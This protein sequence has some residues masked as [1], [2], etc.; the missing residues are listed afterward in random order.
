MSENKPIVATLVMKA[1]GMARQRIQLSGKRNLDFLYRRGAGHVREY[2]DIE[3]FHQEESAL[4]EIVRLP[5]N[6]RTV[7]GAIDGQAKVK[8]ALAALI[9][10]NTGHRPTKHA[11]L[12]ELRTLL[13]AEIARLEASGVGREPEK[14]DLE[15][16]P[17]PSAREVA[18]ERRRAYLRR[19]GE[20]HTRNVVN[21]YGLQIPK[22]NNYQGM[23][24][25]VIEREFPAEGDRVT[26]EALRD[27]HG[28]T[29]AT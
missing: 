3:T 18:I 8:G 13:E 26:A 5:F 21:D 4:R 23:M 27:A 16:P 1:S 25:A 22:L 14:P 11:Q 7:L 19:A 29:G 20:E 28:A 6:I 24:D 10:D 2:T 17:Q 9:A 12:S 15:A